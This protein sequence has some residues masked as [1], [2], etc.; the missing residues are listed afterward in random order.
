MQFVKVKKQKRSKHDL[1][2]LSLV[3]DNNVPQDD[4]V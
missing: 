4:G 2:F 1:D 3:S